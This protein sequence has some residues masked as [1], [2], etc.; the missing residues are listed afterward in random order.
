M[1]PLIL[2]ISTE[3]YRNAS[4]RP[5]VGGIGLPMAWGTYDSI[6]MVFGGIVILVKKRL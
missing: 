6:F 3:L 1:E 5:N 4:M 2:V